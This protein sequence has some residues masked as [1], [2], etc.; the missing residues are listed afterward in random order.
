MRH[1]SQKG[2]SGF[3]LIELL[4][5]VAIIALLISIL[6]PSLARARELAKRTACAANLSGMGK[7]LHTYATE[8]NQGMPISAHLGALA[9][10][11]GQVT[12]VGK[13]GSKRGL[14]GDP[15]RGE[16]QVGYGYNDPGKNISTAR[17]LWTLIRATGATPGSFV[18]PSSEDAKNDEDSPQD[19][20]DFGGPQPNNGSV[21][22]ESASYPAGTATAQ[23]SWAK[24]LSYGYQVP[25]GRLGKPS[26]EG[27]QRAAMAADRGPWSKITAED[28]SSGATVTNAAGLASMLSTSSPDDWRNFN[29]PNHGGVGDG[30]GQNVL[31]SDSHADWSNKPTA[32]PASD[33]I[34][35]QWGGGPAAST[36]GLTIENRI[37]GTSP[38]SSNVALTPLG[39]TDG[40][41]YP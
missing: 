19:F 1:V 35:T 39:N 38:T 6:L 22:T 10:N 24:Q 3:T 13:I 41:I 26:S 21:T 12:Y 29:S 37:R 20:W 23:T 40:L 31:Y 27:D 14:L 18:C 17:N 11:V 5:V 8:G 7:G 30:E 4:V 25:Y 16:I 33:N 28:G 2:R 15:A 34:Y 32:G 9:D 36:A